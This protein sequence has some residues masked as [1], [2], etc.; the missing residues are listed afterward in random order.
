MF[1]GN[2]LVRTGLG[3]N[4]EGPWWL[5]GN[6]LML[7]VPPVYAR[8]AE[9]E[10]VEGAEDGDEEDDE[11][12]DDFDD[13]LEDEEFDEEEL[14]EDDDICLAQVIPAIVTF[15]CPQTMWANL[16]L[17]ILFTSM[18]PRELR[19]AIETPALKYATVNPAVAKSL[20]LPFPLTPA[21]SGEPAKNVT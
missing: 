3:A 5:P 7:D 4:Q 13:D 16:K 15:P 2:T 19:V 1:G 11:E 17:N 10:G 6:G 14:E 21:P 20:I 18:K 9:E 12:D 8:K